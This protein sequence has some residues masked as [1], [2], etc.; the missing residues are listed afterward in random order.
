VSNTSLLLIPH[1]KRPYSLSASFASHAFVDL[2]KPQVVVLDVYKGAKKSSVK[3]VDDQ[4]QA[5][6]VQGKILSPPRAEYLEY[7]S[8]AAINPGKYKVILDDDS[9]HLATFTKPLKVTGSQ[10]N[11]VLRVGVDGDSKGPTAA[12]PQEL[13]V[14]QASKSGAGDPQMHLAAVILVASALVSI[15]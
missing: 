9:S 1:R 15:M 6:R 3:I 7:H 2:A 10:Y 14:F 4:D 5:P 12:F 13:M 11:V 8:V